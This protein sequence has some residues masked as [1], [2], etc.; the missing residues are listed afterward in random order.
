MFSHNRTKTALWRC[1]NW[2][3]GGVSQQWNQ[4][5]ALIYDRWWNW[6]HCFL[7]EMKKHSNK[8]LEEENQLQRKWNQ[9][10]QQA[11]SWMTVVQYLCRIIF[12]V[13]MSFKMKKKNNNCEYYANLLSIL[14]MKSTNIGSFYWKRKCCIKDKVPVSESFIVEAKINEI[15]FQLLLHVPRLTDL[16]ISGFVLDLSRPN[17]RDGSTIFFLGGPA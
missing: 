10:H 1:F 15:K 2:V 9:F 4:V 16:A 5:F 11:K 14:M 6:L 17:S 7:P 12:I 8:G 3:F 13:L